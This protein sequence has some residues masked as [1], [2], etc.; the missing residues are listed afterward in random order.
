MGRTATVILASAIGPIL[1]FG[2]A[3]LL[4]RRATTKGPLFTNPATRIQRT[5]ALVLGLMLGGLSVIVAL[6]VGRLFI[7]MP[8]LAFALIAYSLG[9]DRFL[10]MIQEIDKR[11]KAS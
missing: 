3:F 5:I 8:I 7:V 4:E 9:A 1:I 10:K 2:T 6:F 11:D